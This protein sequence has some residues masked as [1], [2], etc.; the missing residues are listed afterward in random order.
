MRQIRGDA[1]RKTK[2]SP[3]VK[4]KRQKEL[5]QDPEYRK[6]ITEACKKQFMNAEDRIRHSKLMIK[7]FEDRRWMGSVKYYDGP[8]YCE[9]WTPEL[10]ERVRAWFGYRCVECGISQNGRKLS[11]HHVWYNKKSCCDDSPRSLVALCNSCH[12][13]TSNVRSDKR[14]ELSQHFQDII[15]TDYDGRCWYTP[16]EMLALK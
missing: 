16:D 5:W 13:K 12:S 9:K 1:L 10:R 6:R 3:D 7:C 2:R 4:S 14:K 8:Q 11:V 15:D